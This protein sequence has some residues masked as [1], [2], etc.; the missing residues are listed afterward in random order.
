MPGVSRP[1]LVLEGPA[2]P[3]RAKEYRSDFGWLCPPAIS[4]NFRSP[5]RFQG[6]LQTPNRGC[7]G[8]RRGLT[9]PK[10]PV[11]HPDFNQTGLPR[12]SSYG[13]VSP[14]EFYVWNGLHNFKSNQKPPTHTY[15]LLESPADEVLPIFPCSRD[16]F[17]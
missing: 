3:L 4:L 12:H 17:V 15:S 7:A 1:L 5:R 11:P 13:S 10:A 8:L 9:D 6:G 16:P 2:S 14:E